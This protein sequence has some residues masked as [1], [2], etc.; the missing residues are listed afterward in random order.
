MSAPA[1]R[2]GR[3]TLLSAT[4]THTTRSAQ[5]SALPRAP[6]TKRGTTGPVGVPRSC[7]APQLPNPNPKEVRESERSFLLDARKHETI[8]NAAHRLVRRARGGRF[9]RR[10]GIAPTWAPTIYITTKFLRAP[11]QM[12]SN[13]VKSHGPPGPSVKVGR[14]RQSGGPSRAPTPTLCQYSSTHRP[15]L[16]PLRLAR[17]A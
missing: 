16:N 12:P 10:R 11:R 15:T 7:S 1:A 14:A 6:H 13:A 17:Y 9:S 4:A 8:D 2:H 3:S 5:Y